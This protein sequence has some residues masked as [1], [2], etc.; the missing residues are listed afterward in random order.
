MQP[1]E[2]I[3]VV[4]PA[5]MLLLNCGRL[6]FLDTLFDCEGEVTEDLSKAIAGVAACPQGGWY[7]VN[8][9][10]LPEVTVH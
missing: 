4:R 6:T 8:L 5:R 10:M 3:A 2:P 7:S 1:S 9:T